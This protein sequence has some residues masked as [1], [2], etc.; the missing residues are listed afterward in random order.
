M[1]ALSLGGKG[2]GL[3][4]VLDGKGI[5]ILVDVIGRE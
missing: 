5:R 4:V 3:F 1:I 2:T